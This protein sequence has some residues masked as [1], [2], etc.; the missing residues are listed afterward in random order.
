ML[1]QVQKEHMPAAATATWQQQQQQPV[2]VL[3]QF[4]QQVQRRRLQ[5]L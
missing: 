2:Q 5:H 1:A 4:T 3:G